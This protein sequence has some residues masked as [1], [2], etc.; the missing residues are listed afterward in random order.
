MMIFPSFQTV[1][2]KEHTELDKEKFASN[3]VK[4]CIFPNSRSPLPAI[5]DSKEYSMCVI[6][7][8][9]SYQ[10]P[11]LQ[12][13]ELYANILNMKRP[14]KKSITVRLWK[15]TYDFVLKVANEKGMFFTEAAEFIISK[16]KY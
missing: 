2:S 10:H 11:C 9:Q 6:I 16:N 12:I 5:P 14:K 8:K 7:C 4:I 15:E 13:I 3:P 1:D